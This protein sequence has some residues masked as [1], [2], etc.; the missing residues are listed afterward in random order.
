MTRPAMEEGGGGGSS[1]RTAGGRGEGSCQSHILTSARE[2]Q[3]VEKK[4]GGGNFQP[5]N[6]SHIS[7]IWTLPSSAGWIIVPQLTLVPLYY[8]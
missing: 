7:H 1:H 6:L 8:Q 2:G 4:G 5:P 3:N